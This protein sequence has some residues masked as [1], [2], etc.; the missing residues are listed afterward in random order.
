MKKKT[1]IFYRDAPKDRFSQEFGEKIE[2]KGGN[3]GCKEK[4]RHPSR[5]R[6]DHHHRGKKPGIPLIPPKEQKT[7]KIIKD[8][9]RRDNTQRVSHFPCPSLVYKCVGRP[10]ENNGLIQHSATQRGEEGKTGMGLS[11]PTMSI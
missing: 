7:G 9:K 4:K 10:K 8:L 5:Q 11:V 6:N 2:S 1:K 3:G